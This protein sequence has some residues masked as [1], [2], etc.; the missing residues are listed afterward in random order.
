MPVLCAW[1][2]HEITNDAWKNNA[3]NHQLNEGSFSQRKR[4]AIKAYYE[5]MPVREPKISFNNWKRYKI[6]KLIDLKLL[7][8]RIS[9]RSKQVNLNDYIKDGKNFQKEAFLKELIN[10]KR[11]LIG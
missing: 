4:N 8:T 6:G 11:S 10:K 2:D 9:S 7:E 5:W 1:D 3:E